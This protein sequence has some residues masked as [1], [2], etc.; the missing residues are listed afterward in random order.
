MDELSIEIR[1]S[2]NARAYNNKTGLYVASLDVIFGFC[3]KRKKFIKNEPDFSF[4]TVRQ[5][6]LHVIEAKSPK[7]L[8][9]KGVVYVDDNTIA[10][11]EAN[12]EMLCF[13]C[14][15]LLTHLISSGIGDQLRAVQPPEVADVQAPEPSTSSS[16]EFAFAMGSK[17]DAYRKMDNEKKMQAVR[18]K[19]VHANDRNMFS[20]I[21]TFAVEGAIGVGWDGK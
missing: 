13:L 14:L 1:M 7:R 4:E 20:S 9:A 15:Y 3:S 10:W 6:G 5:W 12:G 19:I 21:K 16:H 11:H 18:L 17:M 8:S 2:K